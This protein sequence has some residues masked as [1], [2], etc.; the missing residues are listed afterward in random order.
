M[1]GK[2]CDKKQ[3]LGLA[4]LKQRDLDETTTKV[5]LYFKTYVVIVYP[6]KQGLL[7]NE[8]R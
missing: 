1:Q 4:R 5:Q 6:L 7:N 3:R 2:Q 8:N